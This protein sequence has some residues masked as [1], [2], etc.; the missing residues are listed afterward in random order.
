MGNGLGLASVRVVGVMYVWV[1]SPDSLCRWKLH[2]SVYYARRIPVYLGCTQCSFM[3]Q[4]IDICFLPYIWLWQISQ[5][6][7][8]LV[9]CVLLSD[10]SRH[11]P[12][13]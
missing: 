1:V 5:F 13:L 6:K 8:K 2:V 3:L 10:L 7:K 11:H 4:F 12:L 9:V